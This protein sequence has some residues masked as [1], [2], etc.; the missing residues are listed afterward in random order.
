MIK[1]KPTELMFALIYG[2][3]ICLTVVLYVEMWLSLMVTTLIMVTIVAPFTEELFKSLPIFFKRNKTNIIPF[4]V[5]S[6]LGFALAELLYHNIISYIDTNTMYISIWPMMHILFVLPCA[7]SV[8]KT[9]S[10]TWWMVG[11]L[12]SVILHASTNYFIAVNGGI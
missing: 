2:F 6:A 9:N 8:A 5:L 3:G 4:T 12:M 11:Y 7:M 1:K 10:K